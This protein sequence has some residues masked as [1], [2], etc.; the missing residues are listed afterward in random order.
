[1][2]EDMDMSGAYGEPADASEADRTIEVEVDNELAFKPA[3][4]AEP[5]AAIWL[6]A[7]SVR[8]AGG[9]SAVRRGK[10]DGEG[11]P[12]SCP[13][14][15]RCQGAVVFLDDGTADRE[16]D[17]AAAAASAGGIGTV[18]ALED[19]RQVLRADA[20]AGVGDLDHSA[21]VVAGDRHGDGA[22]GRGVLERVGE[23]VGQHLAQ[24]VGV[25]IDG[26]R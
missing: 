16:A 19:V 20:C 2:D 7:G 25:P 8:P 13:G 15:V 17:A 21:A 4:P 22:V 9:R 3:E 23:Q 11:R 14:T 18:E 10:L 6:P 26:D 5:G 1:M 24:P 12:A